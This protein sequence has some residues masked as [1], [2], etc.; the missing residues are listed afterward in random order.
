MKPA[1]AL[2]A[3]L[4]IGCAS[5]PPTRAQQRAEAA[6]EPLWKHAAFGFG[7]GLLVMGVLWN[8]TDDPPPGVE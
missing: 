1:I 3:L 5:T 7:L 8:F 6:E 4:L 2:A